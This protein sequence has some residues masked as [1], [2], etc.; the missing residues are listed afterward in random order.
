MLLILIDNM[1]EEPSRHSEDEIKAVE[2]FLK[3]FKPEDVVFNSIGIKGALGQVTY[4]YGTLDGASRIFRGFIKD[5]VTVRNVN[6]A[7]NLNS[8][9]KIKDVTKKMPTKLPQ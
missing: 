9:W 1:S 6:G 7:P 2:N 4:N 3:E 5:Q 8:V